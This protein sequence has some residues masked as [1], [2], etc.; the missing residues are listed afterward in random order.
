MPDGV[1]QHV[2]AGAAKQLAIARHDRTLFDLQVQLASF[3]LGLDATIGHQIFEQFAELDFLGVS[4][5]RD[6]PRP[7]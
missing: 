4:G 2:F 5:R 3:G 1:A 7:A 6:R